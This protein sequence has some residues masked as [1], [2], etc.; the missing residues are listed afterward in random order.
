[1]QLEYSPADVDDREL[2]RIKKLEDSTGT[3]IVAVEQ[4]AKYAHLSSKQLDELRHAERELGVV[5]LAY[6]HTQQPG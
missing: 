4:T 5:M 6:E 1:M 3:V 2:A